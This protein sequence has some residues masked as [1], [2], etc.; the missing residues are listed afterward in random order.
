ME[1]GIYND[2]PGGGLETSTTARK[3]DKIDLNNPLDLEVHSGG[4]QV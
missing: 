3:Y 2:T 4:I 1:K